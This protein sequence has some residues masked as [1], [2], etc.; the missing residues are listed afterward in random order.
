MLPKH[1]DYHNVLLEGFTGTEWNICSF[2]GYLLKK[3]KMYVK[4][5]TRSLGLV[6]AQLCCI[7]IYS[8]W[9]QPQ[10]IWFVQLF[11]TGYQSVFTSVANDWKLMEYELGILVVERTDL[12]QVF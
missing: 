9:G 2:A 8:K 10:F 6:G 11:K 5:V 7:Q 1:K 12:K 3:K 4:Y